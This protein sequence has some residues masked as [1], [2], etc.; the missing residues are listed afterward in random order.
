MKKINYYKMSSVNETNGNAVNLIEEKNKKIEELRKIYNEINMKNKKI[1]ENIE[2]LNQSLSPRTNRAILIKKEDIVLL[3]NSIGNKCSKLLKGFESKPKIIFC[4]VNQIFCIVSESIKKFINDLY[5]QFSLVLCASYTNAIVHQTVNEC[6][7]ENIDNLF[8]D[9][10]TNSD[11]STNALINKVILYVKNV[12]HLGTEF[13]NEII[14]ELITSITKIII[15][16]EIYNDQIII[17]YMK[18]DDISK[19]ELNLRNFTEEE[20]LNSIFKCGISERKG[21][22]VIDTPKL[23]NGFAF[24]KEMRPI[25]ILHSTHSNKS[26]KNINI[27]KIS[28]LKIDKK[29]LSFNSV[30]LSNRSPHTPKETKLQMFLKKCSQKKKEGNN[31]NKSLKTEI[32]SKRSKNLYPNK[33][34]FLFI[35]TEH[36]S[37]FESSRL[38]GRNTNQT[39]ETNCT[40]N[41]IDSTNTFTKQSKLTGFISKTK[42]NLI[43]KEFRNIQKHLAYMNSNSSIKTCVTHRAKDIKSKSIPKGIKPYCSSPNVIKRNHFVNKL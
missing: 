12:L 15:Y 2:K 1:K 3:W 18:C 24:T 20:E 31:G 38:K 42:Q 34:E 7:K 28:K 43:Q 10:S 6:I 26:S 11:I 21:Y 22:I 23:K 33:N 36:N 4:V 30:L 37:F 32:Q 41:N 16:T 19:I 17:P 9:N 29:L 35:K 39:E 27:N 8:F 5:V 13:N 40:N 14:F 25:V